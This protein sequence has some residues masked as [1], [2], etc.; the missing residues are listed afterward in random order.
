LDL[1]LCCGQA[2]RWEKLG[3]W[4]YGV[5]RGQVVKVRQSGRELQFEN[6]YED[7]IVDCFGLKDDL[8]RILAE[9]KRDKYIGVAIN[10]CEGL[11]LLRQEPWECL[12]SYICATYKNIASIKRMLLA[13]SRK[14]GEEIHFEGRSYFRFPDAAKLAVASLKE[15]AECEL[16]YRAKYVSQTARRVYENGP[17]FEDLR[18]MPYED[19]KKVLLDFPGVGQKVADC[20]LLFSLGKFEAFPVDVWVRRAVIGHYASHF[21]REFIQRIHCRESL[22]DSEYKRLNLFGRE[23][24]GKYAGYAQEYLY[25]YERV[26]SLQ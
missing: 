22:S 25:H 2:F 4:W 17:A 19:A 14:F 13:L 7:F 21:P 3:D 20:V 5:V 18:N 12:I 1:T 6:V 23:Y 9:I 26:C 15:L 10:Y 8:S 11:R 24:F 16:G